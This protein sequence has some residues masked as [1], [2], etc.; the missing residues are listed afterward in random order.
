LYYGVDRMIERS[1]APGSTIFTFKP[2]PEAYTSRRI[3]VEYESA[4]NK[5]SGA[6]LWTAFVPEYAPTWRLRFPFPRQALGAVRVVQTNA[7]EDQWNVHEFRV[8]DGDRELTRAPRWRLT[9][10]PYPWGIQSAFDNSLATFW[11]CGDMLQPGQFVQVEFGAP[12]AA[13]AVVIETAP[14][15]WGIRLKLDGQLQVKNAAGG[16]WKLLTAAPDLSDAPRPFG[17]R[18]AVAEELKRRGIDYV[19]S[20]E[21]DMGADDLHGNAGIYGIRQVDEYKGARLYQ[22]PLAGGGK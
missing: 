22:L 18:R 13:D 2:I 9:A 17:L 10:R 19:L 14:N 7:G 4:E 5:I 15:Q 21:D 16:Q 12:E 11:M 6:I 20:F 8:F 3:L 1:T